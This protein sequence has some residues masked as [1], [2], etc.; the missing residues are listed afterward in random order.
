[1][2]S[3]LF[4][5]VVCGLG[6]LAAIMFS[7]GKNSPHISNGLYVCSGNAALVLP[8]V[9]NQT[10][11][12][13]KSIFFYRFNPPNLLYGGCEID[14]HADN[15]RKAIYFWRCKGD[16]VE[17]IDGLKK[18]ILRLKYNVRPERLTYGEAGKEWSFSPPAP[19]Q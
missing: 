19:K 16:T 3:F 9:N 13:L 4:L 17:I 12:S 7:T 5:L 6:L 14:T 1:M 11:A 18:L 2:R 10:N 8:H 15:E